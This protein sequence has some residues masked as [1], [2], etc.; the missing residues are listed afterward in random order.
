M[1]TERTVEEVLEAGCA[2]LMADPDNHTANC[3]ARGTCCYGTGVHPRIRWADLIPAIQTGPD[4]SMDD[5]RY[6]EPCTGACICECADWIEAFK[7][8]VRAVLPPD[9]VPEAR[10]EH[11]VH[12]RDFR[13]CCGKP[14]CC[15]APTP[16]TGC[17]CSSA[18]SAATSAAR[19]RPTTGIPAPDPT[20]P[21]SP[22]PATGA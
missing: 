8:A 22:A 10:V 5:Y 13:F 14:S 4:V 21:I 15:C 12:T 18:R 17:G 2:I 9:P 1:T 20:T 11:A 3:C 6:D 19:R 7:T 16:S